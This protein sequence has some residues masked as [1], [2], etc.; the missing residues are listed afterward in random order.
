MIVL[1]EFDMIRIV[2]AEYCYSP[3]PGII[4]DITSKGIQFMSEH[5]KVNVHADGTIYMLGQSWLTKEALEKLE[6]IDKNMAQIVKNTL[7]KFKEM[8][9]DE[10]SV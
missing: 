8:R 1:E 3:T 2:R 4:S 9:K 6:T 5:T 10:D 7:E